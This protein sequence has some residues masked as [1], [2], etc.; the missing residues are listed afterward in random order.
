[1]GV[2][3]GPSSVQLPP[4]CRDDVDRVCRC[5]VVDDDD[6]EQGGDDNDDGLRTTPA[7]VSLLNEGFFDIGGLGGRLGLVGSGGLWS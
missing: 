1:L 7:D 5:C 6:K 4:L 2:V 3:G